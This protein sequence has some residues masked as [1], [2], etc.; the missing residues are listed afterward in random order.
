M[1]YF[2]DESSKETQDKS[3]GK[4]EKV[5]NLNEFYCKYGGRNVIK[6]EEEEIVDL[7]LI[8]VY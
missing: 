5:S 7:D 8:V 4:I 1:D 3:I 2:P 6:I